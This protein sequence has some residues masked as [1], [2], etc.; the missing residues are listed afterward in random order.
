[1][2]RHKILEYPT[3]VLDR[4]P[5]LAKM[6]ITQL[7]RKWVHYHRHSHRPFIFKVIITRTVVD[8]ECLPFFHILFDVERHE[9]SAKTTCEIQKDFCEQRKLHENMVKPTFYAHI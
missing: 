5:R 9:L 7:A 4:N 2:W 8:T 1:M 3:F 6:T